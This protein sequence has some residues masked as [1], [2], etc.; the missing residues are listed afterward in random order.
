MTYAS[1]DTRLLK[2]GWHDPVPCRHCMRNANVLQTVCSCGRRHRCASH[3]PHVSQTYASLLG[4]DVMVRH[5][6]P[7][8]S[9]DEAV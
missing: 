7:H 9:L 2:M 5:I 8:C 1:V 3:F 4:V 6:R